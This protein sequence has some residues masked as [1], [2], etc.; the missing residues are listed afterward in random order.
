MA[1]TT[2]KPATIAGDGSA[3]VHAT[4]EPRSSS[5]PG[6]SYD[7]PMTIINACE[8]DSRGLA[9]LCALRKVMGAHPVSVRPS[10]NP[11][12]GVARAVTS[13]RTQAHTTSR[14][15][16]VLA[17]RE[18]GEPDCEFMRGER[19]LRSEFGISAALR[20]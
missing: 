10:R 20:P 16:V 17:F 12:P 8:A 3:F 2:V 18:N 1:V 4:S 15:L 5:P 13:A 19:G 11:S 9:S 6:E 14:A 7:H